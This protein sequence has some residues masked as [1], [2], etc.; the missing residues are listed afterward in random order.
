M[1]TGT[2]A[3][4]QRRKAD[5]LDL[6]L[7]L[8]ATATSLNPHR[9]EFTLAEGE[10]VDYD[11][12]IIATCAAAGRLPGDDLPGVHYLRTLDDTLTLRP[13]R[14]P[15]SRMVVIGGGFIGAGA[16]AIARDIGLSIV[17]AD[18]AAAPMVRALG[19]SVSELLARHRRSELLRHPASG[20][21]GR[22]QVH[23]ARPRSGGAAQLRAAVPVPLGGRRR[24]QGGARCGAG[25]AR[26][27]P[28]D[29]RH[30]DRRPATAR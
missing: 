1:G 7:R 25:C 26:S 13:R 23:A 2:A 9:R 10:P 14:R 6:N 5:K 29:D 30:L 11:G 22:R 4:A 27:T 24:S 12:L 16:A 19:K 20:R 8:G 18:P 17:I 28:R 3:A 21:S 15:E